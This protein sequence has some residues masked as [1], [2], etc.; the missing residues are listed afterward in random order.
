MI[1]LRSAMLKLVKVVILTLTPTAF[2]PQMTRCHYP[3][4]QKAAHALE[5]LHCFSLLRLLF[6]C[7]AFIQCTTHPSFSNPLYLL[8]AINPLGKGKRERKKSSFVALTEGIRV[9][10]LVGLRLL[11]YANGRTGLN[12]NY[13]DSFCA[14]AA[15]PE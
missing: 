1:S 10:P 13:A 14:V 8:P 5:E 2:F 7:C 4:R 12:L 3:D 11:Y 6:A 15:G 9:R